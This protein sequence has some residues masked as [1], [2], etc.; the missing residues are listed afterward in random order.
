MNE[1][2]MIFSKMNLSTTQVINAMN[3]KWNALGLDR[4][5]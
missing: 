2:A 1:V 4:D 3:T 5:L